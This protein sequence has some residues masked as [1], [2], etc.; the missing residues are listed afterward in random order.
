MEG[1][2]GGGVLGGAFGDGGPG[3]GEMVPPGGGFDEDGNGVEAEE[4]VGPGA[5][6]SQAEIGVEGLHGGQGGAGGGAGA[7]GGGVGLGGDPGD[8]AGGGPEADRTLDAVVG[9]V[10]VE[11]V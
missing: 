6:E 11:G 2:E 4:V 3:E 1:C 7:A 5:D 10:H 9:P 8:G